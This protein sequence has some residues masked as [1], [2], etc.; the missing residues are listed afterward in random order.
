MRRASK[1]SKSSGSAVSGGVCPPYGGPDSSSNTSSCNS[2]TPS[3]PALL[4]AATPLTKGQHFHFPEVGGV[5]LETHPLSPPPLGMVVSAVVAQ[6][7]RHAPDHLETQCSN[8]SDRTIV[9]SVGDSSD[10]ERTPNNLDS[11]GSQ[12]GEHI[13]WPRQNSVNLNHQ[14]CHVLAIF[15][16]VTRP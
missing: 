3:S 12:E 13:L 15:I 8:D 9:S 11:Q 1:G 14:I 7:R 10:S 6:P 2:S 4:G 5:T 16:F